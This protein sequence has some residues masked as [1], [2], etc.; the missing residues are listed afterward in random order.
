MG[1][2]AF[3]VGIRGAEAQGTGYPPKT[4]ANEMPTDLALHMP[5]SPCGFHLRV[6]QPR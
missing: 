2:S 4:T 5:W 6:F 3:F 1:R